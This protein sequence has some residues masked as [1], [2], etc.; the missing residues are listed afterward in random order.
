M[1]KSFRR[2]SFLLCAVSLSLFIFGC[3][4]T[5]QEQEDSNVINVWSLTDEVPVLVQNY[6]NEN[7]Q[8]N[9]QV[10]STIP[11]YKGFPYENYQQLLD[12]ALKKSSKDSPDV[13]AVEMSHTLKYTKGLMQDYAMPYSDLGLD[14]E[15]LVKKNRIADYTVKIGSNTNGKIDAL[16]YQTTGGVFIYRRSI[17][18]EVFGTDDPGEINN[19]I[20]AS[21][22]S[23]DRF[24]IAAKKLAAHGY[25]IA[26]SFEDIWKPYSFS[27]KTPWVVDGKLCIDPER[28]KFMNVAKELVQNGWVHNIYTWSDEWFRDM[29]GNSENPVFGFFGPSWFINYTLEP[30]AGDYFPG[31]GTYGDWA[32]CLSPTGFTWGG[33]WILVNKNLPESKKP[34]VKDLIYHLTLDTSRNGLL[35]KWASGECTGGKKDSVASGVVMEDLYYAMPL[36]GNQNIFELLESADAMVSVDSITDYDEKINSI[37]VDY[38]RKYAEGKISFSEAM[39][40]FKTTVLSEC[41]LK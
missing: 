31:N 5:K 37:W 26:P 3:S 20:G 36:L 4:S 1:K 15:N 14:A 2:G 22:G 18:K 39:D 30:N 19:I 41:N 38:V 33:T 40:G 9:V 32:M 34:V 35:Y 21:T 23:W 7:P 25:A 13:F 16:C 17:A 29:K 11:E 12:S 28:E 8:Y 10:V 24:L 27:A 6:F